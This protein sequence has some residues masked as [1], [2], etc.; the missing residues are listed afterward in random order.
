MFTTKMA[1]RADQAEE[2]QSTLPERMFRLCW[3]PRGEE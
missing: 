3:M 1:R 2:F